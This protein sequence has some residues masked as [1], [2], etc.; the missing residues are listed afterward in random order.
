MQD[1]TLAPIKPVITLAIIIVIAQI[2]DIHQFMVWDRAEIEAGQWWRIITGNLTHTNI[3]H[4]VINLAGLAAL[5][6]LH[7]RHYDEPLMMPIAGM[8]LMIGLVMFLTP[9]DWYAGLSGVLYGLFAWGCVKDITNKFPPGKLLLAGLVIK[10]IFD[11][12]NVGMGITE[13]LIEANVAHQAHW[14]GT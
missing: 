6:A 4:L 5:Y 2:P 13:T 3:K 9:F 7:G 8:M 12:A 14:A 1:P 10:L 11:S